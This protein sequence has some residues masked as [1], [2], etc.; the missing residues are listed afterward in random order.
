MRTR[1]ILIVIAMSIGGGMLAGTSVAGAA[2]K[3]DTRVTI[4][5][6][7][8]DFWGSVFSSRPF[9]CAKDRK[10]VLFKQ[11]GADQDPRVD[12]K[13]ASDTASLNGDRYMWSTGNTGMFGRFYARAGATPDC[14]ADSSETIRSVRP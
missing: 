1:L 6:E 11:V 12:T 14:R 9:K 10:V 13:V 3:A 8:G 5:T 4:K 7:N 2:T